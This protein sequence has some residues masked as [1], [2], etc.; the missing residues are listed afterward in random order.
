[1]N[2][3]V[4]DFGGIYTD[5]PPPPAVKGAV[6]THFTRRWHHWWCAATSGQLTKN[7]YQL[8][9]YFSLIDWQQT[10][11]GILGVY[12]PI[13]PPVA[14][15]LLTW[16]ESCGLLNLG[17]C[18]WYIVRRF[19]KHLSSEQLLEHDQ[20]RTN[21]WC[22]WTAVQTTIVSC[23]FSRWTHWAPFFLILDNDL[24]VNFVSITNSPLRCCG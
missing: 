15:P 1:V 6:F 4:T 24:G 17:C 11:L 5:I 8:Y 19:K 2:K 10:L 13:Y 20:S 18:S 7:V 22:D 3:T 21:R 16:S 9:K 23:S 12:L 14:T